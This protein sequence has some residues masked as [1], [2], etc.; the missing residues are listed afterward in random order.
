M[1]ESVGTWLLALIIFP[2]K[3]KPKKV[4]FTAS[5]KA[6]LCLLYLNWPIRN[7]GFAIFDVMASSYCSKVTQVIKKVAFPEDRPSPIFS[8]SVQL[9]NSAAVILGFMNVLSSRCSTHT[10]G[11]TLGIVNALYNMVFA[12]IIIIVTRRK[13]ARGIP[14]EMSSFRLFCFDPLGLITLV[15][16]VWEFA[17]VCWS[18]GESSS[19]KCN[20]D[21][22]YLA[23]LIL[24][25]LLVGLVL[26][27]LTFASEWCS[28]PQWRHV[29][30]THWEEARQQSYRISQVNT[31]E[32]S[33]SEVDTSTNTR[34][35]QTSKSSERSSAAMRM[36]LSPRP[37]QSL[38]QVG[39]TYDRSNSMISSSR[40]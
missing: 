17:W 39:S 20:H 33:R 4:Y 14:N 36:T 23:S 31:L 19:G 8:I 5:Q 34:P 13:I 7:V 30:H 10:Q 16:V 3:R 25:S 9:L 12:V 38:L 37:N 32:Y 27:C 1:C 2:F 18:I 40:A 35:S 11:L 29:A 24:L 6:T 15:F 28:L 22:T 21:V 26:F